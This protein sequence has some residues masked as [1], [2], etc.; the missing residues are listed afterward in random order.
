MAILSKSMN[1]KCYRGC[2][3][4]GTPL[5]HWWE[6]KRVQPLW[7]TIWRLLKKKTRVTVWSRILLLGIYLEK[8]KTLIQKYICT[9]MFIEALFIIAKMCIQPKC[10]STNEWIKKMGYYLVIK[11]NEMTPLAVTQMHLQITILSQSDR[12]RQISYDIS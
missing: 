2:G 4:M 5:H 7:T 3:E 10:P 1:N 9:P 6:C 12:G 11:R 8:V